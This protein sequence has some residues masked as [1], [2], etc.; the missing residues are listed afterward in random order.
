M[1]PAFRE[2]FSGAVRRELGRLGA[3]FAPNSSHPRLAFEAAGYR[4][5][6]VISMVGRA[7]EAG[8]LRIPRW[9]LNT[10]LRELR[11]GYAVWTWQASSE[12]TL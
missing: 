11:D 6:N 1:S 12:K 8:T 4:Q 7:R 10:L 3:H 2:R 9:L 5:T